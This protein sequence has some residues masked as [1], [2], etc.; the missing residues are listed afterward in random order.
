[1]TNLVVIAIVSYY[2]ACSRCTP[3]PAQP[4]ASGARLERFVTVAAPRDVPFGTVVS[5]EGIGQRVVMDRTSPRFEGRW[6]VFVGDD[7][8]A[9][10]RAKRL[11]ITRRKITIERP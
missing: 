4:T 6:D 11:G 2:C 3:R 10:E 8:K 7:R 5:I 1:M 9:H